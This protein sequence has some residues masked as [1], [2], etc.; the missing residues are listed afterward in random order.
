[1]VSHTIASELKRF[2]RLNLSAEHRNTQYRFPIILMLLLAASWH[3]ST[4]HA[5]ASSPDADTVYLRFS[6]Q[7]AEDLEQE[8]YRQHKVLLRKLRYDRRK[9]LFLV[10]DQTHDPYFGKKGSRWIH[11][12]KPVKGAT[13]SF[14]FL[15][16]SLV[17]PGQ[18]RKVIRCVPVPVKTDMT[19]VIVGTAREIRSTVRYTAM[20]LDRGFYE[21]KC[22]FALQDAGI[23]FLIRAELRGAIQKKF[24]HIKRYRRT[25]HWQQENAD[26][27]V[28]WLGWKRCGNKRYAW[29]FLTN[30][31]K[32]SWVHCLL[33]YKQRWN[34]ENVFKATDGIQLRAATANMEAR[35]F[36]VLLSFFLYN[37][38]QR[39]EQRMP[40]LHFVT[41]MIN[42]LR[43][44]V[45]GTGPPVLF[46]IPGWQS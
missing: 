32:L 24:R 4:I 46:H 30:I 31:P 33:W 26:P 7:K 22:A 8:F 34:I 9:R 44:I 17:A 11:K 37:A 39:Q 3:A 35:L 12:Y 13:G 10:V 36:A 21:K 25:L 42:A 40:L 23:P 5:R 6:Y 41:A 2:V 43:I 28:L 27:L 15:T 18:W 20:L 38:W 19:A 1:M 45:H 16:F 14:E 29:G